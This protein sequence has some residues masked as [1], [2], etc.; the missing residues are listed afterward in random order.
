MTHANSA[1]V[2]HTNGVPR[3][4]DASVRFQKDLVAYVPHLRAFARG[5]C[6]SRELSEDL[7]QE[8]LTKAW[9]ARDRFE[10]GT[11]LKAWLFTILRNE[12]H[13]HGR[14]AWRQTHWDEIKG[15]RIATPPDSQL[16]SAAA[17]DTANALRLLPEHQREALILVGAGGFSYQE[18]S[19]ICGT[20]VGTIKSRVA[21]GRLGLMEIL[22]GRE[23]VTRT[24]AVHD[25]GGSA[26][27][28]AQLAAIMPA[29]ALGAATV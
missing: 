6:H 23:K 11:N 18:A 12:F 21:R 1:V 16:W 22:D 28:L 26:D 8:T 24:R 15:G 2:I 5:L 19:A 29:G 10:P 3:S 7:A 27:I 9:R 17:A 4:S 14:R 20:A 25:H 13:S